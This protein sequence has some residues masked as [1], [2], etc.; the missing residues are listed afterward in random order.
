MGKCLS[1]VAPCVTPPKYSVLIVDDEPAV[2]GML[3][4]GLRTHGFAVWLAADGR[5][6]LDL[7]RRHRLAIDVVLLDVR[8]PGQDGPQTLAALQELNPLIRCC[9]MSGDLGGYTAE[10]LRHFGAATVI[11]KPFRLAVLAQLLAGL[12]SRAVAPPPCS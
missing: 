3:G 12:A 6:A 5:E 11:Q 1:P 2:R 10:R 4:V 9:F 8:M 7:Y